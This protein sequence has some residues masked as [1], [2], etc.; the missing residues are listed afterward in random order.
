MFD[1]L[2]YELLINILLRLPVKTLVICICTCRT[3]QS[4]ITSPNFI[5]AYTNKS[6][7][8][9]FV[10]LKYHTDSFGKNI[11]RVNEYFWLHPDN[12]SL[13]VKDFKGK[14]LPMKC[15]GSYFYKIV[16]CCN[17]VICL[18][19]NSSATSYIIYLWNPSIRKYIHVPDP[20]VMYK[21][22]GR[23]NNVCLGF[24]FNELANDYKI[25]RVVY[26]HRI[27]LFEEVPVLV[28]VYSVSA[29]SWR[30]I[31][32]SSPNHLLQMQQCTQ[33]FFKGAIHWMGYNRLNRGLSAIVTFD[34]VDE[35]FGEV[36]LPA[37]LEGSNSSFRGLINRVCWDMLALIQVN[38]GCCQIWVMKKYGVADS[39]TKMFTYAHPTL[40][41]IMPAISIRKN[42]DILMLT[43]KSELI[44]EIQDATMDNFLHRL[45]AFENFKVPD[46]TML[47]AQRIGDK[48]EEL[49]VVTEPLRECYLASY[50]ESLALF[51]EGEPIIGDVIEDDAIK[52]NNLRSQ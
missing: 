30:Y 38:S 37:S 23:F 51:N 41:P 3:L 42:K 52:D 44:W 31:E 6:K 40:R 20:N 13:N 29:R 15:Y 46:I 12:N 43:T 8:N 17:G 25:I 1:C 14:N 39:W 50:E 24:G 18:T 28:E 35:S 7:Q 21:T 10:F 4:F 27:D 22:H 2:I 49:G 47:S 26:I 32:N 45:R 5:A 36:K 34:V 33:C 19:C 9:S 16:G 11:K 48:M